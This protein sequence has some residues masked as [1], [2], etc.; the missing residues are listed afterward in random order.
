MKKLKFGL[1]PLFVGFAILG[2]YSLAQSENN[3]LLDSVEDSNQ[4]YADVLQKT[5]EFQQ[6]SSCQ[7]MDEVL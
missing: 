3:E 4:K 7:D 1:V 5:L 6:F 2:S